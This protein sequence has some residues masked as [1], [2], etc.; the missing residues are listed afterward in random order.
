MPRKRWSKTNHLRGEAVGGREEGR[1]HL[2]GAGGPGTVFGSG[3]G[4]VETV[5]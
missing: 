3:S 5:S 2:S 1:R 4:Q